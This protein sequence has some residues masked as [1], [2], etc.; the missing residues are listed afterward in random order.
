[1]SR[2]RLDQIHRHA[3]VR[4]KIRSWLTC[5]IRHNNYALRQITG[6]KSF[7]LVLDLLTFLSL[8]NALKSIRDT[9]YT[10]KQ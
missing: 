10:F 6:Q 5:R 9:F 3:H 2:D 7:S 1:V 8:F 4:L